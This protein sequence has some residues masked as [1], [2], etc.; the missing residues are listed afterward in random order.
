MSIN[1]MAAIITIA[2]MVGIMFWW[3]LLSYSFKY[4]FGS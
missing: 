3:P 4:W 1:Q 2:L